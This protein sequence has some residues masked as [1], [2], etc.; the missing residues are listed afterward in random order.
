[1]ASYLTTID[2]GHF[3]VNSYERGGLSYAD[4]V[5]PRLDEPVAVPRTGSRFALSQRADS[6]YKR[7]SRTISVPADGGELSF[8]VNRQTE[9]DWDYFMVEAHPVGSR[10]WTTL[11]DRNGHTSRSTGNSC[12]YWLPIHPFLRHYQTAGQ[13]GGCRPHGTTGVWR[14]AT[15][16]SDGY[17]HWVVDLDRYA[18]SDV[19]VSLSTVSDDVFQLY[20]AFVD[21]VTAPGEWARPRSRTTAT[22][23]TAGT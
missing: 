22:P 9:Q 13:A 14:A 10:D 1:M 20:G 18:G 8:W 7:L 23:W 16:S 4:A 11:P 17:E 6:S 21:D 12:P 19:Q 2:I 3:D 15:G 5:D